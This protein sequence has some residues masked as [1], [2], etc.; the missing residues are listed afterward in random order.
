MLRTGSVLKS[1]RQPELPHAA[2]DTDDAFVRALWAEHADALLAYATRL[3]GDRGSAEDIVQEVMLRAWRHADRLE[4]QARSLRPWLFT[5]TA[6][7]ATDVHRARHARPTE[8]GEQPL[9]RSPARNDIDRALQAWEVADG[10]STLSDLHRAV[11]IEIYYRGRSVAEAATTLGVP[12]G[13]V[14]S[15]TYYALHALRLALEEGGWKP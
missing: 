4:G 8:V 10:L 14:K 12:A 13:T 7:L 11:L 15:R 3:T 1:T 9:E 5:V 6:H 2:G